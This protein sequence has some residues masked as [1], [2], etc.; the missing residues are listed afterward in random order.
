MY[1]VPLRFFRLVTIRRILYYVLCIIKQ[2]GVD[3]VYLRTLRIK[4][5][6][7]AKLHT[8]IVHRSVTY[9]HKEPN[10]KDWNAFT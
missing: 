5:I 2:N 10:R 6:Q 9:S 3:S 4:L 1:S 8:Y 7:D